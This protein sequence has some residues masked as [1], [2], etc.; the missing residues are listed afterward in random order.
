[1]ISWHLGKNVFSFIFIFF[2]GNGCSTCL[3]IFFLHQY[4]YFLSNR[5][6]TLYQYDE[7]LRF[8][9]VKFFNRL[10]NLILEF[11]YIWSVFKTDKTSFINS[12]IYLVSHHCTSCLEKGMFR[13]NQIFVIWMRLDFFSKAVS[14]LHIS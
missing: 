5:N 2:R 3:F 8:I 11:Q 13:C 10:N 1:M 7:N 12:V 14:P 9:I 4:I 6:R